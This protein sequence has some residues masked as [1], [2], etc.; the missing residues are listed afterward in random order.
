MSD[1]QPKLICFCNY[2]NFVI[3][4]REYAG[5][6][7]IYYDFLVCTVINMN[8]VINKQGKSNDPKRCYTGLKNIVFH[9]EPIWPE[10]SYSDKLHSI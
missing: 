5:T 4:R 3:V 2:S 9:M 8:S 7:G 1:F 6:V 10:T